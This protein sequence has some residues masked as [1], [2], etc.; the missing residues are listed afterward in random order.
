MNKVIK[1][2]VVYLM[3]MIMVMVIPETISFGAE[4]ETDRENDIIASYVYELP[5]MSDEELIQQVEEYLQ[6]KYSDESIHVKSQSP[7]GLNVDSIQATPGMTLLASSNYVKKEIGE[8]AN[9]PKNGV[10]FSNGGSIY[11]QDSSDSVDVGLSAGVYNFSVSI[12]VGRRSEGVTGYSVNCPANIACKLYIS[13]DITVEVYHVVYE[14]G[15]GAV[16]EDDIPVTKE[17]R[18]YFDIKPV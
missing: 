14:V 8:A 5:V 3:I 4:G 7:S 2:I 1:Q 9:Q 10:V 16:Y 12:S 11:W 13:K 18:L 15:S 17:T 6:N